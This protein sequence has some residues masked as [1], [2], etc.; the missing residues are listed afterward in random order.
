MAGT[1]TTEARAAQLK[2]WVLYASFGE[3]HYQ[4][5]SALKTGFERLGVQDVRL[6]DLLAKAH[7]K[8]NEL[9]RFIY[10]K[11]YTLCPNVYGFVYNFTKDMRPQSALAHWLH[12]IGAQTLRKMI[13]AERPDAI[14][15]TFPMLALPLI[16]R[17]NRLNIP[18][19]N[20]ITDFDLHMRWVHP[21]VRKYFVATDDLARQLA[22]IGIPRSR[23]A[24][25]GIPLR[26]VFSQP[27]R[28][29]GGAFHYGLDPAR[30]V[31]L[32]MARAI[33]APN[34]IAKW[35]RQLM[36]MHDVQ[37]AIVCGRDRNLENAMRHAFEA[38]SRNVSVF[39][40]VERI[41]E[42][43]ALSDCI[44]TKPGGL[45]L[46]EAI[47][48][49]LPIFLYRPIPGQELGNARYLASKGAAVICN[50]PDG[51]AR[52]V[53]ALLASRERMRKMKSSLA[54]LRKET[55]ADRIA[56][57]ILLNLP[58]IKVNGN[59]AAG[60]DAVVPRRRAQTEPQ[61]ADVPPALRYGLPVRPA[62]SA[63]RG[64]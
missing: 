56:L 6:I 5:A 25:T 46:S 27:K 59:R 49:G 62:D 1:T 29:E 2:L 8:L 11:S 7:P 3:G 55:A 39:G 38:E 54:S 14:I 58:I 32:V 48:T 13:E 22:A 31:V 23:I 15:H 44:I 21:R 57:D 18:M 40:Y 9:S 50:T 10:Q 17:R 41:D 12:S 64:E 34:V 30:R 24:V 42:L 47:A 33:G 63:E 4:A 60:D 36:A 51:L 53:S 19:Y 45:T 26:P 16:D 37:I 28:P 20:V 61:R 43:M 35:C 52:S